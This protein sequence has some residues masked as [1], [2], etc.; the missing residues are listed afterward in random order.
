MGIYLR[1]SRD[2]GNIESS[3][4]KT[5]REMLL[6]YIR[7]NNLIYIDEYVDD[8]V[9]GI[10]F[11]RCGFNRMIKDIQAKKINMVIT[12]DTSRLGRDHIEFGYYVEKFFPENNIRYVAI[13]DN[14]DTFKGD[15][16]MLLFKSAF[17]DMYVKDISNKLRSSLTTKKKS[18][19]FVGC[20]APYGYRKDPNDK[21]KLIIDEEA[22]LIVK[23]IFS[24]Y[25]SG[26]SVSSICKRL[27][28]EN[29]KTPSMYKNMNLGKRKCHYGIWSSRTVADILKN[30]TYIGDLA[31]AKNKKV[32]YKSKK[33]IHNKKED[34]IIVKD[35][36]P[37][38]IDEET[39]KY[40]NS[41]FIN[42]HKRTNNLLLKGLVYCKECNH[43]IGF[44]SVTSNGVTRTYGNCNY[45]LKRRLCTPHNIKY[46][47]LEEIVLENAYL[48]INNINIYIIKNYIYNIY[49]K[50]SKINNEINSL[51]NSINNNKNK[52]EK[53]YKDKLN[54]LIT[55]DI[56]INIYN[57]LKNKIKNA[58]TRINKLEKNQNDNTYIYII[59]EMLQ[60][61]KEL[62]LALINKIEITEDNNINI[63]YNFCL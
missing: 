63:Y 50:N 6:N 10:T 8:G 61:K 20:Y 22:A 26:L 53:I 33:V 52:I 54:E 27:T 7:E 15:N 62:I 25:S 36:C 16:D 48:Y 38:I 39:Y 17:N 4:I 29:V 19:K 31:Q 2:D 43:K 42:K 41:R 51:K 21:N 58:E 9:S 44:R 49:S 47:K 1:L 46:E 11:D 34:W 28:S 45:Y 60:N 13:N 5:Q 32:S 40:V 30:P 14:V 24:L 59:D 18:G 56:Y 35:A 3:S 23:K 55:E 12:K 37:K 57:E